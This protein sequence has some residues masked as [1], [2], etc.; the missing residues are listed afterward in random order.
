LCMLHAS[1]DCRV[2]AYRCGIRGSC[3]RSQVET[4]ADCRNCAPNPT[5]RLP[6]TL[7]VSGGSGLDPFVGIA[8]RTL[9]PDRGACDS[10]GSCISRSLHPHDSNARTGRER[11]GTRKIDR[12]RC[13]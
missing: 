3:V 7:T 9:H 11:N 2:A 1:P 10:H 5:G 8:S 4:R 13:L 12:V 6:S